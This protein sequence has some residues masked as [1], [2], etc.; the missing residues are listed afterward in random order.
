[1]NLQLARGPFRAG[2]RDAQQSTEQAKLYIRSF[3]GSE[4]EKDVTTGRPKSTVESEATEV[5]QRG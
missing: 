4:M 5:W 2:L 1:M 3:R